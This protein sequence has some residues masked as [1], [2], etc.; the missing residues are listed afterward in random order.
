MQP[1]GAVVRELRG[2]Y[3]LLRQALLTIR[4]YRTARAHGHFD[5][6]HAN[7]FDTLPAA[8]LLARVAR[9]RL[10]YDAHELYTL[11]EPDPPRVHRT[12]TRGCEGLLARRADAVVTVDDE[13]AAELQRL[14]RLPACPSVVL[15]CP[16]IETAV[17]LAPTSRS[18]HLRA[19]YQGAMGPGRSLDDLLAAAL[20]APDIELT[21]RVAGADR[22]ALRAAVAQHGLGDRVRV[23]DPVSPD[24]L[25]AVLREFDVGLIID[26]PVTPNNE[27]ALPNK[28]FEYLMAGL[29]VVA[30]ALPSLSRMIEHEHVGLTFPPGQPDRLGERLMRLANDR[31]LLER[32]RANARTAALGHLN[33]ESQ[34]PLLAVAWGLG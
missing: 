34:V 20:A 21:I 22:A 5:V 17:G 11:R 13:I 16:P 24:V 9:A 14:L 1:S 8:W 27:F 4:L 28:L 7:D 12:V 25:V 26:R 23:V 6:V 31:P 15:N 3:R 19:V 10:V 33:A 30:P 2:A 32:L 29:A 18:D